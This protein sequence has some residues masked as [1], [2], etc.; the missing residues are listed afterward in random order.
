MTEDTHDR[1]ADDL[2]AFALGALS[3][4]EVEDLERHLEGCERCQ[5]ELRWLRPAV[6]V[7]PVSVEQRAP[8][9]RLRRRVMKAIRAEAA[10]P[11]GRR[12]AL[13]G[14]RPATAIA[15]V[16][17][18]TLAGAVGYALR[19]P[20]V[21]RSTTALQASAGAPTGA[22]GDLVRYDGSAT[23]QMRDLPPARGGDVYQAWVRDGPTIAPSSVF[24]PARDGSAAAGVEGLEGADEVLV[25]REPEGGSTHPSSAPIFRAPVS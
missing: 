10:P 21:E 3:R 25:T 23:L 5:A 8:P 24:V 1:W 18:V 15:L 17:A 16:G 4:S 2:P 22:A 9:P 20:G 13:A 19:G 7:L 12:A 14:L 6:D 11:S